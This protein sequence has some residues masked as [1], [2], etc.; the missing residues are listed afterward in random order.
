MK[1][2]PL[3]NDVFENRNMRI[4]ISSS[5]NHIIIKADSYIL[6]RKS[7]QNIIFCSFHSKREMYNLFL[8]LQKYLQVENMP[9]QID[10]KLFVKILD[11][12][13]CSN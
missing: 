1:E 6:G 13:V 10:T 9:L 4:D 12:V 2:M 7:S 8:L 3:G 11:K 5:D